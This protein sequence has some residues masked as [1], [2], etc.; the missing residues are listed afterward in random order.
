MKGKMMET[1]MTFWKLIRKHPIEIPIIQRDY[2]QGRSTAKDIRDKLLNVMYEVI[3]DENKS[4]E[5]D[6]VYGRIKIEDGKFIP[7]DG[8]Q[9]LTTLFLLHWY[10]ALKDDKLDVAKENLK[11][12]TYETRVTSREFCT[13]LVSN[14]IE[15]PSDGACLTDVIKNQ[16]WFFESWQKDP[17]IKSML[18]MSDA[19]HEKFKDTNHLFE[20]LIS[21]NSPPITFQFL[22]LDNF[23]LTDELYIKM[24]A[25]GKPLTEFENFK[26]NFE[27]FLT[28]PEE[29][30]KIDNAWTDLFW[31]YKDANKVIDDCKYKDENNIIDDRFLNFFTNMTL[32]FYLENNEIEKGKK[33]D[34]ISIFDIYE[35]VYGKDEN[36]QR[37][38]KL[39]DALCV[40]DAEDIE[41]IFKVFIG[42]I[43]G[44]SLNE[45]ESKISYRD[46]A[47]FYAI[48]LFLINNGIVKI[49]NEEK[50]LRWK[51][52]AFNLINNTLIQRPEELMRA[53][54]SLKS[55]ADKIDDIYSYLQDSS[56]KIDSFL[57]VQVEEEKIKARLIREES[58]KTAILDI[59]KHWYFDGQIGFILELSKQDDKYDITKFNSYSK[60]LEQLFDKEL[61]NNEEFLVQRALLA[62]GDY[63][64]S[65]KSNYTFCSSE[66]GLRTKQD[67][68][69]KVFN[70]DKKRVFL[71]NLLDKINIGDIR[72]GLEDIVNKEE[73]TD[74]REHFVKKPAIL[75]YC[76]KLQTRFN[77]EEKDDKCEIL[78]L[79]GE[80]TNGAHAEYY[81]YALYLRLNEL[82]IKNL[83]YNE[84]NSVDLIKSVELNDK[85]IVWNPQ[86][87]KFEYDNNKYDFNKII[88]YIVNP[89]RLMAEIK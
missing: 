17:T 23:E 40:S 28:N 56:C 7:L 1:K 21:E 24:N 88:E 83:K 45:S 31:K 42:F 84:Q 66:T 18:T 48:A 87:S 15:L 25:R 70:D 2:A 72:Q 20:K 89:A 8:Q 33:I 27:K 78:L 9:R 74:W 32:S 35:D 46:R 62:Q 67:N 86:E 58:W 76:K 30:V 81:S 49:E 44:D 60:K 79:Q 5:L 51:R 75:K 50:Y 4:I 19:I 82:N 37:V 69:R 52:V 11:K 65:L 85:K 26:A 12:F 41:N 13:Q 54:Q 38:I 64:I 61:L 63:L 80:R 14:N 29:K 73:I 47:R 10:L 39:L 59:E 6:F 22:N 43:D 71:K 68:W 3:G 55:L 16:S 36:I 34:E 77:P 57:Q 53:T